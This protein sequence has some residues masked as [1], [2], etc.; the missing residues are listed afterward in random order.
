MGFF[1]VFWPGLY[2]RPAFICQCFARRGSRKP[3]GGEL[4]PGGTPPPGGAGGE[5]GG[6]EDHPDAALPDPAAEARA[7]GIG[8]RLHPRSR[9][10][11]HLRLHLH[12][13]HQAAC[14]AQLNTGGIEGTASTWSRAKSV[15]NKYTKMSFLC[16]MEIKIYYG[17]EMCFYLCHLSV[18]VFTWSTVLV[19]LGFNWMFWCHINYSTFIFR[20]SNLHPFLQSNLQ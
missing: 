13:H 12:H 11:P 17:S 18:T 7:P 8:V 16:L 4:R 14:A 19:F 2:W 1:F 9:P 3:V 5:G 6:A 15:H 20:T 10:H